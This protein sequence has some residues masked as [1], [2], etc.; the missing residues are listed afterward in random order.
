MHT[1]PGG[2]Q[3]AR[4]GTGLPTVPTVAG[5]IKKPFSEYRQLPIISPFLNLERAE[6]LDF[7]N[8]NTLVRP[9]I[10]QHQLGHQFQDEFQ[11][12]Q[13]NLRQQ[14]RALQHLDRQQTEFFQGHTD[15]RFFQN[16]GTYFPEK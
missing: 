11:A 12:I 5:Q 8:Y 2:V 6:G 16:T 4:I 13:N 7:D 3:P 15:P 9:F 1:R 14:Q 10:E